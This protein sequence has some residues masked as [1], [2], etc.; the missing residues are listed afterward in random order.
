MQVGQQE[1]RR[2]RRPRLR[3]A[4]PGQ[5]RGRLR[6]AR[7]GTLLGVCALAISACASSGSS[8]SANG[9]ISFQLWESH[10]GPPVGTEM[11]AL[12]NEF[13][14]TH[15]KIHVSIVVTKA[16]TKLLA[17]VAAGDP[18]VLAEISHYDGQYVKAGALVS[19]NKFMTGSS[20]VN[21][22][23]LVPTAWTNGEVNGQHYRLMADL[24]LSEVFYNKT[25]FASA[26]ITSAP[27]TWAQLKVD[28]GL[29]KKK[30]PG[31]IPLGW[32]DSSAH[33][34]PAFMS[35]GG[36]MLA[37]SNS[38][39]HSVDFASAAGTA[40]FSYFRSLYAAGELQFHHGTTLRED[41]AAGKIA[42]IDGTSAGYQKALTAVA[43]KFPV[44]AFVE[45]AG[46]TGHAYNLAQGL[47]FV[48]PKGHSQAQDEAAWTFVQWW[49]GAARQASWAETTGFAPETHAGIAAIPASFLASHPGLQASL[50]AAVSPD[51]F[52]RP[53]SDSYNEVQASLDTEFFN[54]VTGRQSV[55]SALTELDKQGDSYMSGAS[56]L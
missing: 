56:E 43:G 13:N 7:A 5:R 23:N 29:I 42:M 15:K 19:W 26:G 6:L 50:S 40:T 21:A 24:K 25:M 53:V 20:V 54:A 30:L 1:R 51:T 46:S 31:V 55:S 34:L 18:P 11:T 2:S 14:A 38:V 12:V 9:V 48:L 49:F 8:S 44:G 52:G 47:G 3:A 45:P 4:R 16:S 35:N 39:G 32:K 36:T 22:A 37:G 41:L 10:N 33:I 17:A 28:V 27:S